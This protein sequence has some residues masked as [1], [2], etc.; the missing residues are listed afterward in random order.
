MTKFVTLTLLRWRI[1]DA[2]YLMPIRLCLKGMIFL[3]FFLPLVQTLNLHLCDVL[4]IGKNIKFCTLEYFTMPFQYQ[5]VPCITKMLVE[6]IANGTW[7]ILKCIRLFIFSC[8]LF[9]I[10]QTQIHQLR[11]QINF[12]VFKNR[13]MSFSPEITEKNMLLLMLFHWCG[14]KQVK[15][16]FMG[17]FIKKYG[18]EY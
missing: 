4:R 15:F 1:Y 2:I 5:T 18:K 12:S 14:E 13:I 16:R 9:C 10:L 11:N 6:E 7:K 17:N 3:I 8:V